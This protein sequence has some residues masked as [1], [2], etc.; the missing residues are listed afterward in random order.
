MNRWRTSR[1]KSFRNAFAGIWYNLR[2][3]PN[4]LIQLLVALV[5]IA[6]GFFFSLNRGEWMMIVLAM[7][8]VL[9]AEAMNTSVEKLCD[10]FTDRKDPVVR[11][12]K[13]SAAAAVL[14]VALTAAVIGVMVFWPHLHPLLPF[15]NPIN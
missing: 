8:G 3:E 4:F 13:D 11:R 15:F 1:I 5:V 10:R 7:G 9:G 2:H 12:I 14:I 6:A